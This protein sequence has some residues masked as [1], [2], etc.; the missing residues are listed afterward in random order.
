VKRF[1]PVSAVWGVL[2]IVAGI[3]FSDASN[4]LSFRDL[5][6]A[7]P[8]AL[9]VVGLTVIAKNSRKRP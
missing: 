4:R 1:D 7:V 9:I 6:L 5:T 2:F 3:Y 8:L